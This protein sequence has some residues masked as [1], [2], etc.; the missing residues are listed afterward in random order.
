[1]LGT[2]KC[3]TNK[4]KWRQNEIEWGFPLLT[5]FAQFAIREAQQSLIFVVTTTVIRVKLVNSSGLRFFS[6]LIRGISYPIWGSATAATKKFGHSDFGHSKVRHTEV[7]HMMMDHMLYRLEKVTALKSSE[8]SETSKPP[9]ASKLSISGSQA[10]DC[11]CCQD[12]YQRGLCQLSG[13]HLSHYQ[14]M[15]QYIDVYMLHH[16]WISETM[17]GWFL[18][19]GL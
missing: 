3:F 19:L 2:L 7:R 9:E 1:M 13:N 17:K 10:Q 6:T 5:V 11:D 12:L 16:H 8:S 18:L 15:I 4:E 14:I